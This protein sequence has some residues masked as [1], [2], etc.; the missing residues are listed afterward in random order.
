LFPV[1]VTELVMLVTKVFPGVPQKQPAV[2]NVA[3]SKHGY[4]M[5]KLECRMTN[6]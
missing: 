2:F 4:K 3:R 1:G 6:E 5:T